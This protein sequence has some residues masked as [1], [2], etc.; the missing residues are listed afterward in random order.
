MRI[1]LRSV[2]AFV[3]CLSATGIPAQADELK[4][5]ASRAIWTV[6]NEVG[7]EFENNSGHKLNV[8]TGL[9]ADFV[10]R[11]NSGEPFDVIAAPPASLNGLIQN[12]KAV[13]ASKADLA[14]SGYGVVVRKGAPKP[15]V[16][17]VE[18]FKA[19]LLKAKSITYLP[20]PGVPQIIERLGLK[21][22]LASKTTI[23]DTDISAELVAE[24]KIELGIV[25]IT[26]SFTIP[27]AELAGPL[28]SE[29]QTYTTFGAAVSAASSSPDAAGQ[30]LSFL[31][32]PSA[33]R[34][35]RAQGME[36]L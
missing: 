17:S 12:G 28:P 27:G 24:G 9:S 36:P 21:E 20:V 11:I 13:A 1:P 31:K 2:L 35:I 26:Q 16:S 19:S 33:V 23:P 29:I 8:I 25:A 10:R 32:G 6:L 3:M 30:L 14:R 4:V 34:V 18:A 7:T 22:A 15:D 5:L